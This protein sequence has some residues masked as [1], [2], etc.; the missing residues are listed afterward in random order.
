MP[1]EFDSRKDSHSMDE[2]LNIFKAKVQLN[3]YNI[4]NSEHGILKV[5]QQNDT[6]QIKSPPYA[7]MR[8]SF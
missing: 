8:G 3:K 5:F 7:A 4:F 2:A 6:T 1:G